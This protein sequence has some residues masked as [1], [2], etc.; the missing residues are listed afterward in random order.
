LE[1]LQANSCPG[2]LDTSKDRILT[3]PKMKAFDEISGEVW[4]GRIVQDV[5]LSIN[6]V[7]Q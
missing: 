7:P 3:V 4:L 6:D 2:A 5:P 1:E